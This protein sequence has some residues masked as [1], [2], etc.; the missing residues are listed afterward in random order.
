MNQEKIES[1]FSCHCE[2][3]AGGIDRRA[4]LLDLSA[5]LDLETIERVLIIIA[6]VQL[7]I[8]ICIANDL[9]QRRHA[10]FY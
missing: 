10:A 9:V 7:Q 5:V 1:A 4:Q 6:L 8:F 2:S 3:L